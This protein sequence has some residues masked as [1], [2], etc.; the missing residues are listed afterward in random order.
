MTVKEIIIL[1]AEMIGE[2]EVVSYLSGG[3]PNDAV[4]AKKTAE[5]LLRCYNYI[6]DE[7]ACE[8]FPQKY[9]EEIKS[10]NDGKIHFSNL[11]KTP[12]KILRVFAENGQKVPYKLINDYIKVNKDSVVVE[13][14]FKI[15]KETLDDESYFASTVIGPYTM[16]FGVASQFCIE[17]GR[18]NESDIFQNKYMDAL[19]GRLANRAPLQLPERRWI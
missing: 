17:R 2:D 10:I 6:N 8:Y 9:R 4:Y 11:E 3:A 14:L 7:I 5:L 16:A 1:T 13:Y 18:V 12:F 19:R 15:P